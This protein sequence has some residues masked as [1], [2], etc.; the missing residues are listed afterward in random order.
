MK[1]DDV[2]D[3]RRSSPSKAYW[4]ASEAVR[5]ARPLPWNRSRV[6]TPSSALLTQQADGYLARAEQQLKAAQNATAPEQR[7]HMLLLA[8]RDLE[9]A[10][11]LF[12]PLAGFS[13]VNARLEKLYADESRA[14][15]LA[16]PPAAQSKK[17]VRYVRRWR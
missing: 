9:R 5:T 15:V 14:E 13:N 3:P 8:Q 10:R 16:K 4:V 12:E 11:S 2:P 17:P 7:R 6:C 1:T